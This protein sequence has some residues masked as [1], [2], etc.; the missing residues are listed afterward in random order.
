VSR[1][2]ADAQAEVHRLL[3]DGFDRDGLRMFLLEY[4]RVRLYNIASPEMDDSAICL[5][6]LMW[7]VRNNRL[8]ELVRA[9]AVAQP[10]EARWQAILWRMPVPL[11]EIM[12]QTVRLLIR[13]FS[14]RELCELLDV[15]LRER[16]SNIIIP[17]KDNSAAALDAVEWF[18]RRGRLCDLIRGAAAQRSAVPEWQNLQHT[19]CQEQSQAR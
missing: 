19:H 1:A 5:A 10:S 7:A 13:D 4:L 17:M 11:E 16:S 18:E 15:N 8:I 12:V 2:H 6:V 3:G 14:R 9:G